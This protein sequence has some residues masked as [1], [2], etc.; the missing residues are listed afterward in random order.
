MT[1]PDHFKRVL[2]G[3]HFFHIFSLRYAN[4]FACRKEPGKL[5]LL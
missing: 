2:K 1:K 4:Y 3:L 5:D